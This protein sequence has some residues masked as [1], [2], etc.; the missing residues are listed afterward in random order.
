MKFGDLKTGDIMTLVGTKG[1][2]MAIEK[3]HPKNPHFWLV[4][5]Y[6]VDQDRFTFDMLNPDYDLI[7]GS[8]ISQ[9]GLVT[10]QRIIT[11]GSLR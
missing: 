7:P 1:V 5:W 4:V 9:D 6:L 8:T 10:W 2:V 11:K 3:P